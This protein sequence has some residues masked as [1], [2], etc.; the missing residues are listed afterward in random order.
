MRARRYFAYGMIILGA[1]AAPFLVIRQ[2]DAGGWAAHIITSLWLSVPLIWWAERKRRAAS[3]RLLSTHS[4][5]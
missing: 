3:Y 4:G 5:H 2:H 1:A